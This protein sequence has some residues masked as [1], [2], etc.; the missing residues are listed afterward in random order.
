MFSQKLTQ[1][2]LMK[3]IHKHP[4]RLIFSAC[5]LR[6]DVFEE[7]KKL[8]IS[9]L[10]EDQLQT[11]KE[12]LQK[13]LSSKP[14]HAVDS[15][16]ITNLTYLCENEND[17]KILYPIITAFVEDSR[18]KKY[19]ENTLKNYFSMCYARLDEKAAKKL[20]NIGLSSQHCRNKYFSI[21]YEL[22]L[23]AD[24][25][26]IFENG[27]LNENSDDYC[28]YMASLCTIGNQTCFDKATKLMEK[29]FNYTEEKTLGGRTGH[30]YSFFA[31]KQEEFGIAMDTL[32]QNQRKLSKNENR[33][34]TNLKVYNYLCC[35]RSGDAYAYL[36]NLNFLTYSPRISLSLENWNSFAKYQG[37]IKV[38]DKIETIDDSVEEM[39]FKPIQLSDSMAMKTKLYEK[40]AIRNPV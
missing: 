20:A 35:K 19:H 15:R 10:S 2:M 38:L 22:R 11:E 16:Q 7:R 26:E 12:H 30:L 9:K 21:L 34:T 29:H 14:A 27:L 39:V 33:L 17:V 6:H 25:I 5:Y 31:T 13:V 40:Q 32:T 8:F 36:E 18:T 37:K 28:Y 1:S 24:I 3:K 23:F 4:A